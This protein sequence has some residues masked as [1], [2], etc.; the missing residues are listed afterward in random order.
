MN[1]TKMKTIED[2]SDNPRNSP[3]MSTDCPSVLC[4]YLCHIW[5]MDCFWF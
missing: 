1:M 4:L 2:Q 3:V 5:F